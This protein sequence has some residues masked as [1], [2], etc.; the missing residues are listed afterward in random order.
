MLS[1][2]N[3]ST[4]LILAEGH[5]ARHSWNDLLR[6]QFWVSENTMQK[7]R[8]QHD[9]DMQHVYVTWIWK[10][11]SSPVRSPDSTSVE[12]VPPP[13]PHI[14]DLEMQKIGNVAALS[15]SNLMEVCRFVLDDLQC[16]RRKEEK[17]SGE[18]EP[19]NQAK[20]KRLGNQTTGPLEAACWHFRT[21]HWIWTHPQRQ[22]FLTPTWPNV[23]WPKRSRIS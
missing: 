8:G 13:K 14:D 19:G 1:W 20:K 17:Q 23:P 6:V 22:P 15:A 3:L 9:W 10:H 21:C 11:D 2:W 7:K 12:S 16:L 18:P 5:D 4:C